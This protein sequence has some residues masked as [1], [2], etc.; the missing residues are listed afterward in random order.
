M[1][2][3]QPNPLPLWSQ[4]LASRRA[5]WRQIE[6][7]ARRMAL[8][9]GSDWQVRPG[10]ASDELQS[11][12]GRIIIMSRRIIIGPNRNHKTRIRQA[13]AWLRA[14][15]GIPFRISRSDVIFDS[16]SSLIAGHTGVRCVARD[17]RRFRDILFYVMHRVLLFCSRGWMEGGGR[18]EG[19][20]GLLLDSCRRCER[21]GEGGGRSV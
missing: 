11:V 12:I 6:E 17:P 13:R 15:P 20:C 1:L 18:G 21:K 16:T 3:V 2:Y 4:E 14:D 8:S 5:R 9:A 19:S 10:R 7:E